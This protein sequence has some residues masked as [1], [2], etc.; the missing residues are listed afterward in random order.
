[1]NVY[2]ND[3]SGWA[4]WFNPTGANAYHLDGIIVFGSGANV[5]TKP[6]IYDN[7]IHGDFTGY[8]T[9]FIFCTY[10]GADDGSGSQ[11]TIYNNLLVGIGVTATA[12]QGIYF[13]RCGA[14]H[15]C[16]PHV[17]YN[18]TVV[19]FS[20]GSIYAEADT[21][22]AYTIR[23]NIIVSGGGWYVQTNQSKN[24]NYTSDGNV[25]FGGRNFGAG[26]GGFPNS[27]DLAAWRAASG[28][29]L[30]S[31]EAD[32]K[33]DVSYHVTSASPAYRRGRNLTSLGILPLDTSAPATFGI[34]A[35]VGGLA[36]SA[37]AAW[38]AGIYALP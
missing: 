16:G 17:M 31:I 10:D 22:I 26:I 2:G 1:V 12:A 23:N 21:S 9:G 30:D 38:D 4:S 29:D 3:I 15:S 33:L 36:R 11:C 18:N 28:Q 20:T 24:T 8:P 25:F 34:G 37:T 19:G 6:Q 32:P 7:K 5:V 13:H 35:P 14:I 27:T